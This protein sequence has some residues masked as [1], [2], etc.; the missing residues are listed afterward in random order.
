VPL[1][2]VQV[3]AGAVIAVPAVPVAGTLAQLSV[4][5]MGL[6][7]VNVPLQLADLPLQ[8]PEL[9]ATDTPL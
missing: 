7:T 5:V 2:L 6:A 8:S 4:Y 3:T 9:A 1:L